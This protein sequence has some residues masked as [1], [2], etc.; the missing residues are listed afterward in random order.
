MSLYIAYNVMF[1]W[2]PGT[3]LNRRPPDLQ[4]AA[5]RQRD[6]QQAEQGQ[7][8]G[9]ED[10]FGECDVV[11]L[12]RG[13]TAK[14][15]RGGGDQQQEQQALAAQR[16]ERGQGGHREQ[17]RLARQGAEGTAAVELPD[18]KQVEEVDPGAEASD[19][20]PQRPPTEHE[21]QVGERG[22]A[23]A[24]EGSRQ[25]DPRVLPRVGRM[26]A[27]PDQRSQPGHEHRRGGLDAEAA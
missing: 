18:G 21:P 13:V 1:T 3:E 12:L 8:G 11:G 10:V 27:Q 19:G 24:P 20:G 17:A 7:G 6:V 4:S 23:T 16:P 2:C 9:E 14:G 22:G 5:S 26:L 15:L 25:A